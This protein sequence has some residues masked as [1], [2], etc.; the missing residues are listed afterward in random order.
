MAEGAIIVFR[1]NTSPEVAE[2]LPVGGRLSDGTVKGVND[3]LITQI[4]RC[5]D[6]AHVA[7]RFSNMSYQV[8]PFTDEEANKIF[9]S[10]NLKG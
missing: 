3:R 4:K 9:D 8:A 6:V 5:K 10:A 1:V 2:L 7:R